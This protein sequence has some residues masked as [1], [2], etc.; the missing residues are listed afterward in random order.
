MSRMVH[1]CAHATSFCCSVF[2]NQPHRTMKEIKNLFKLVLMTIIMLI[3]LEFAHSAISPEYR[4]RMITY[5]ET[6]HPVMT[7]RIFEKDDT[8]WI[9]AFLDDPLRTTQMVIATM[10]E[11]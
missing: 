5:W 11:S 1:G 6:K 8:V 10:F 4:T 2:N 9:D 7:A 3:G